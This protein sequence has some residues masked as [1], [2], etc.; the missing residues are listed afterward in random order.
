MVKWAGI[1]CSLLLTGCMSTTVIFNSKWDSRI[2]P[3][4]VDYFDNYF[5]GFSGTANVNLAQVCMDQKPYAVRRLKT[6]EDGI[7]T[8]ITIGIY[9]PSTIKVWCGE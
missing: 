4:Y 3:S 2:K 6:I 8:L 7:L 1:A 9:S 5:L